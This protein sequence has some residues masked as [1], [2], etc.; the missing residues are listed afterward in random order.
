MKTATQVTPDATVKISRAMDA[1]FVNRVINDPSVY[2]W[3]RGPLTG[4]IDVSPLVA[5]ISNVLLIGEYGCMLFISQQQGLYDIHTQMLPEGRGKWCLKFTREALRW[6]FTRTPAVELTSRVPH[7]NLGALALVRANKMTPEFVLEKG[8]VYQ[9]K[10]IPATS[11]SI[12]IQDWIRN[13]GPAEAGKWFIERLTA[14]YARNGITISNPIPA[15][16]HAQ[17][18]A[19]VEMIFGGQKE[20][21]VIFYN[22]WASMAGAT[23]IKI[24]TLNPLV[25][26][27]QGAIIKF[28]PNDFWIMSCP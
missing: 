15:A 6:M 14:E 2:E 8:W 17:V 3:I 26:E 1:K 24:I 19:A 16:Y 21:G 28:R 12:R 18:G 22:R 27:C 25:I 9:D 23:P 4:E 13:F 20:K 10:P 7:G 11:Y 5:D